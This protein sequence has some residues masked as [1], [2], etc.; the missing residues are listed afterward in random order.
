V[1]SFQAAKDK[2]ADMRIRVQARTAATYFAAP[3]I[4]SA[5]HDGSHATSIT[6]T[7]ASDA[8]DEVAADALLHGD[9]VFRREQLCRALQAAN[10]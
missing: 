2:G 9:A 10:S 4:D 6:K 5:H 7:W 8:I 1:G 3:V